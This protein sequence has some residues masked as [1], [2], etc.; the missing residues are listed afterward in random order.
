MRLAQVV[1][2]GAV[3]V[4]APLAAWAQSTPSLGDLARQ[5]EI[6]RQ[7]APKA[8][9]SY[10]TADLVPD[11]RSVAA[12]TPDSVAETAPAGGF[13]SVS[14]GRLL[15]AEEIIARS[16]AKVD[17]TRKHM[18]ERF[19]RANADGL[20][21]QLEMAQKEVD[22]LS[23]PAER[24]APQQVLRDKRLAKAEKILQDLQERWRKLEDSAHYS[25]VPKA[26]LEPIPT[27]SKYQT[28]Q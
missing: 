20:R 13:M 3:V 16:Q 9:K 8:S 24:S 1:V 26:W 15:T 23:A 7:T 4:I 12:P 17:N 22:T 10:T 5:T 6:S 2:G 25:N 19:W 21:S 11:P 18:D 28:P 14:A 27:L